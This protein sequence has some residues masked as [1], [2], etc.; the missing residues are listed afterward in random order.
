[1]LRVPPPVE[2]TPEPILPP[3]NSLPV[4]EQCFEVGVSELPTNP[5][6]R[7]DRLADD[8][9]EEEDVSSLSQLVSSEVTA[10]GSR[11]PLMQDNPHSIIWNLDGLLQFKTWVGF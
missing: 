3:R 10:R 6:F 5:L 8:V 11:S 7:V 4:D 1:M 2:N 9:G